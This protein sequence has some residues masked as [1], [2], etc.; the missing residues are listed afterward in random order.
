MKLVVTG[1]AGYIGSIVAALLVEDG[2][3]VIVLD[4]LSQGQREAIPEGARFV[5]GCSAD[6]GQIF[7]S[8]SNI[9]AVL[10]FAAFMQAGESV[11]Q[12]EKYWQNNTVGSL[13]LLE[14]MRQLGI[15]K[16]IFSSTA[17]VYGNPVTI[18]ITES[19][20]TK[21]TNPYGMTKLAVDMAVA[22]ECPAHGL[23]ATSL[24]YF[25]VAGAYKKFGERHKP[26][27]HIIPL[28]L[29][30]AAEEREFT[31]FGGDYPTDDGTCVRDYIHVE[32]L[33]R[34]HLLALNK[35]QAGKHNI[36]NLGNGSGFSNKQVLQTV[37][38]VTGRKLKFKIGPRR[39][40]D[41]AMLVASSGLAGQELGW[42]PQKP[43]LQTMV[44]DAWQFYQATPR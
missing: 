13:K 41:P 5:E 27:T 43:Q 36:Y 4:N 33:A 14:G 25:N 23:A 1:G 32:D 8:E 42:K 20:A 10:H 3:E 44:K 15:K 2:H 29:I 18:P 31:I 34:A 24:R 26:E 17:A 38:D 30:A 6:F 16:L 11:E 28:A 39:P 40:G 22:S 12:P 9:E 37:E 7:K 19:A 35:L 21:P